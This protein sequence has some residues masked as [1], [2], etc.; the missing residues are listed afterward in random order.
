M[1]DYT[2]IFD[3]GSI[4][5]P[6]TGYGSYRLRRNADG[7]EKIKR[8]D[9]G[10]NVTNNIAEYQALIAGLEDLLSMIRRAGKNPADFS[11]EILGDSR[12]VISQ[13]RGEWKVHNINLKP[14]HARALALFR[15]FGPGSTIRW[16]ARWNNVASLGH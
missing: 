2:L 1:S 7:K 8:L 16:H 9:F 3:G 13:M 14:L 15:E 6:G 10:T 4:G 11:V 5:N 12:L